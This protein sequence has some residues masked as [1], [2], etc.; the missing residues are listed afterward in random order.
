[1]DIQMTICLAIIYI[2]FM[3]WGT[4]KK[5]GVTSVNATPETESGYV[6]YFPEV[7]SEDE[8][9]FILDNSSSSSEENWS[10][11]TEEERVN[12]IDDR[13][14]DWSMDIESEVIPA[15][16]CVMIPDPWTIES[17]LSKS[18]AEKCY[19]LP[20]ATKVQLALP[21]A[22]E[23]YD[24][25]SQCAEDSLNYDIAQY[26][27]MLSIMNIRQLKAEA[28]KVKLP[29]YGKMTKAELLSALKVFNA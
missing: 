24:P 14:I 10:M 3:L 9:E 18:I 7:K 28:K 23:E 15:S 22:V 16:V 29:R 25:E 19:A 13:N 2:V 11:F 21:P 27:L 20:V 4:S 6:N 12:A 1:M 26:H 17:E 5:S 8:E